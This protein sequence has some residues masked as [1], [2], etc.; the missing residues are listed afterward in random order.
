M[1]IKTFSFISINLV[2]PRIEE[3]HHSEK[4]DFR[5]SQIISNAITP[6]RN[7]NNGD[8]GIMDTAG[9]S[10]LFAFGFS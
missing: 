4:V 6:E 2:A 5:K 3:G 9:G 7:L 8:T 1:Q 10:K